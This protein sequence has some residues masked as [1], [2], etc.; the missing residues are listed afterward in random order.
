LAPAVSN[1]GHNHD[2]T[3]EI[4]LHLQTSIKEYN[5][6]GHTVNTEIAFNG[7]TAPKAEGADLTDLQILSKELIRDPSLLQA[8]KGSSLGAFI[9]LSKTGGST[10]TTLLRNGCHSW[11]PKPC[12]RDSTIDPLNETAISKLATY[13]H[14][15]DF[16]NGLL[17]RTPHEF[18]TFTI[19]DPLDRTIS[20]YRALRP[21]NRAVFKR[22]YK[23]GVDAALFD[24]FPTLESYARSL[25]GIDNYQEG[26]WQDFAKKGDCKNVAK[27]S[28][29]EGVP[30]MT[31]LHWNLQ[32]I[33]EMLQEKSDLA[34]MNKTILVVRNEFMSNDWGTANRFLGQEG[35]VQFATKSIRN[36]SLLNFP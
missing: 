33:S 36:S 6:T 11:V 14:L 7:S 25:D 18:Y 13:Y 21:E 28:M 32:M 8:R 2:T 19:R 23:P 15:P 29:H 24:S 30:I 10:L 3:R 4:N 31:H 26:D 5:H 9:H 20:A 16:L 12:R 27:L 22:G 35:D 1:L 17:F 34:F